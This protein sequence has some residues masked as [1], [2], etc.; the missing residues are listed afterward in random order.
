MSNNET[1]VDFSL[2]KVQQTILNVIG[3]L[4]RIIG[5]ESDFPEDK[6]QK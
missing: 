4:R 6:V 1:K 3:A 2:E 5:A